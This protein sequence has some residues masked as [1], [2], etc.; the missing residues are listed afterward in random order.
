M[1][2]CESNDPTITGAAETRQAAQQS[3]LLGKLEFTG[4]ARTFSKAAR[5]KPAPARE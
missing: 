4:T 1:D 2:K 5:E 3:T